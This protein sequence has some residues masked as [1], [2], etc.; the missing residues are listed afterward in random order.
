MPRPAKNVRFSGVTTAPPPVANTIPCRCESSSIISFSLTRKPSSP[1]IS[2][3]Q[4]I[5]APVLASIYW[6]VSTNSRGN[7]CANCLPMVVLPAPTGPIRNLFLLPFI[8]LSF[9]L[10][11]KT[12]EP[13]TAGFCK[14]YQLFY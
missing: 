5:G 11:K 14:N 6:S 1:S 4:S 10:L 8:R 13:A 2:K 9:F 12:Q 7:N 3:I